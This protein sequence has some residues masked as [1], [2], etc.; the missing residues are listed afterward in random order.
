M[1]YWWKP[2]TGSHDPAELEAQDLTPRFESQREAEEW[3]QQ[4]FDDLQ[5]LGVAEVSLYDEDRQ[6]YGPMSL[7]A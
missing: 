1:S 2:E 7:E 6:V 3:L 4:F 5:T